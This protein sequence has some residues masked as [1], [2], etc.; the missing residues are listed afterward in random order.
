MRRLAPVFFL[1]LCALWAAGH[2]VVDIRHGWWD[3][4]A[5]WTAGALIGVGAAV[6]EWDASRRRQ[7]G[8]AV[9]AAIRE[10][11]NDEYP[12]SVTDDDA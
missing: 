6:Y 3:L 12:K 5:V 10:R 9:Y 2:A 7:R 1:A 8:K 11:D 4:A